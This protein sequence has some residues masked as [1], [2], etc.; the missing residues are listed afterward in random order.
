MTRPAVR[1]HA[2]KRLVAAVLVACAAAGG[3][4]RFR[5]RWRGRV[6]QL[7]VLL[8]DARFWQLVTNLSEPGGSFISDNFVSNESRFQR[9]VPEL[10]RTAGRG[11]VYLG[12]GPDQNFTY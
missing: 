5:P 11:S 6:E 7:P 8:T 3:V 4:L 2:S 10:K 1:H 12:V 9:V